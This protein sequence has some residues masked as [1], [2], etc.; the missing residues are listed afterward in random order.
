MRE[1]RARWGERGGPGAAACSVMQRRWGRPGGRGRTR[2][3]IGD[4]DLPRPQRLCHLVRRDRAVPVPAHPPTGK[5]AAHAWV[6]GSKGQH[7]G[8]PRSCT[9]AGIRGHAPPKS[10]PK[11]TLPSPQTHT[12]AHPRPHLSNSSK[13]WASG[14][15][16]W[17]EG[18][19]WRASSCRWV[20]AARR[21]RARRRHHTRCGPQ[22]PAARMGDWAPHSHPLPAGSPRPQTPACRGLWGPWWLWP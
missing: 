18:M 19:R 20:Q 13:M 11:S 5:A 9:G 22:R 12:Q 6:S 8:A 14:S 1:G 3:L 15:V 17:P 7:G 4:V 21:G 2:L 16:Y 10:P